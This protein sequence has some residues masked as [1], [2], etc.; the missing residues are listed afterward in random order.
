MSSTT[1]ASKIA[2]AIKMQDLFAVPV[3]LHYRGKPAFN[4]VCGGCVSIL[5]VMSV[6]AFFSY[7]FHKV[8]MEPVYDQYPP[9]YDFSANKTQMLAHDGSTLSINLG[10]GGTLDDPIH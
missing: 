9:R 10:K 5:L 2:N 6:I 4:T 3:Q 7:E 1:A 8:N